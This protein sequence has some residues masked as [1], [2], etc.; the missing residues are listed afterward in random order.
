MP[1]VESV[2]TSEVDD[3]KKLITLTLGGRID[4]TNAA[5]ISERY[6]ESL[7]S[8]AGTDYDCL[9]VLSASLAFIDSKC[10]SELTKVWRM[11]DRDQQR[12]CLFV[13]KTDND[14]IKE[15]F[16]LGGF[17]MIFKFCPS[18]AAALKLLTA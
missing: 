14:H 15:I 9:I 5:Q 3:Q 4:S 8:A 10:L 11:V 16:T 1:N 13:D 6:L 18:T 17:D 7:A 12:S 2:V